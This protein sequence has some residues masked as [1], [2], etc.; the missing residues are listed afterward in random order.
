MPSAAEPEALYVSVGE[1]IRAVRGATS[2]EELAEAIGKNQR[3]LSSYESGRVAVPLHLVP[4]IEDT[5]G[6][7]RGT[8]FR[9]AGLVE[10]SIEAA[11]GSDPALTEKGRHTVLAYYRFVRDEYDELR[12]SS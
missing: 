8:I 4:V 2:Q 11:I 10:D 1:A 6:A 3:T 5:C 7:R 9:R 12:Y